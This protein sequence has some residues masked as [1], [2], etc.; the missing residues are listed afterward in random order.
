MEIIEIIDCDMSSPGRN[1][2][3]YTHK[4]AKTLLGKKKAT[5]LVNKYLFGSRVYK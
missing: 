4:I 2:K 5:Q 3:K 1:L